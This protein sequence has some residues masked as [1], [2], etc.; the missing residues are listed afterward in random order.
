MD[1]KCI[2][3]F[4]Y[5]CNDND[6]KLQVSQSDG[7]RLRSII[8][9]SRL[10]DHGLYNELLV[11]LQFDPAHQV[12]YHKTC[13]TKYVVTAKRLSEKHKLTSDPSPLPEKRTRSSVGP[14]FDWLSQCFYCSRPCN[15]IDDPKHPKRWQP[16][17]LV[18]ETEKKANDDRTTTGAAAI[19][20]R[21]R[22]KCH[23]RT[24]DWADIVL[25]RLAG[26]AV[27]SADLHAADARYHKEC[28][29]RFFN[30]K[31]CPVGNTKKDS[32]TDTKQTAKVYVVNSTCTLHM[33][34]YCGR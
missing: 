2:F 12:R 34:Y 18:R 28:Y 14:P 27:R 9:A 4:A 13:V 30:G 16:A 33:S 19:E 10:Q 5:N 17:Y 15:I 6:H 24:D 21:I 20:G 26:L 31:S 7:D 32:P 11:K 22:D 25:D 3:K 1:N 23:E 8:D 29:N